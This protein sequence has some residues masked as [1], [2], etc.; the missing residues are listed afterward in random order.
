MVWNGDN[1]KYCRYQVKASPNNSTSTAKNVG[2]LRREE[3]YG[4][5]IRFGTSL[6]LCST[7]FNTDLEI[8][9]FSSSSIC[10]RDLKISLIFS[11]AQD[12]TI[13]NGSTHKM[14]ISESR[15]ILFSERYVHDVSV[16]LFLAV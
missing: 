7:T 9:E 6:D 8:F 15:K 11:L 14:L 4:A 16:A 10:L 13:Y 5:K 3:L 1:H 12:S 2:D